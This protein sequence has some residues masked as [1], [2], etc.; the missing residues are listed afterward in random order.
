MYEDGYEAA[1]L[2]EFERNPRA[3]MIIFNIEVEEERRTYHITERKPVRW[4]N[5]GRYG[6]VS[7]AVRRESLLQS[8]ITFSLLF[9]GGAK[10]SNG[11]DS[12]FLTEFIKKA[13]GYILHR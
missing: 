11:E 12:L 6:A 1:V 8:G 10:Y 9:G 13:T 7:F 2:A 5:C 4:Y 3:D